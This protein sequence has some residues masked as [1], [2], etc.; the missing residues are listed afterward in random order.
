MIG[1]HELKFLC[2][3]QD[4]F[5]IEQRLSALAA[6][7]PHAAN[8]TYLITSLYFDDYED[9]CC[10][11]NESGD[12]VRCKYR[13]RYYNGDPSTL[14]L[15]KKLRVNGLGRKLLCPL[16]QEQLDRFY[17][18]DTAPLLYAEHPLLRELASLSLTRL[19]RPKV[20]VEY[21]RTPFLAAAGNVRITIDRAITGSDHTELFLQRDFPTLAL[22]PAGEELLE[23]K[24]DTLLSGELRQA[25][26]LDRM[27][28]TSYSKYYLCRQMLPAKGV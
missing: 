23:V 1:R 14:H 22:Q 2:S 20:I 28:Q 24:Y 10:K 26:W 27:P 17:T 5:V 4:L 19:M 11:D 21:E 15:E 13:A 9:S 16:T 12:A 6:H 25:V 7:D 18:G 3:S 8:G